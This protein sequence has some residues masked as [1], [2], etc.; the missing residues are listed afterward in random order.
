MG[1]PAGTGALRRKIS[2]DAPEVVVGDAAGVGAV[3]VLDGTDVANGKLPPVT[4]VHGGHGGLFEADPAAFD[5]HG[6][7]TTP[8]RHTATQSS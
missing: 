5:E 8:A 6:V 7:N 4:G 2:H 1:T 3:G